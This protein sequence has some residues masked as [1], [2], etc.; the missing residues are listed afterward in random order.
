[1]IIGI[2]N[3]G[4]TSFK[5]KII[6]IG[7]NN[8]I[9]TLG[10]ANIDKI[11]TEGESNFTHSIGDNPT[12]REAVNIFGLEA[13]INLCLDWY[14]KN[15]VIS[16]PSD[17]QAMGF[18][19]I[20]GETN[21]ANMLTPEILAE[22]QRYAFV[23]PVHNIP[24]I[25]SIG[26]FSKIL[27]VPMVGVFEPSFHYSIPEFR[28]PLSFSWDWYEKLGIKKF[29]FHGSSHRYLTAMAIKLM[30]TENM[31]L[32]TIH[33]GGSSS[34]SAIKNGKSIDTSMSFSPNSGLL[35]GTRTGDIDGTALLYAMKELGI[36]VEQ[37]QAEI[38]NNAGL[39]GIASIGTE[40]FREILQASENGNKKARIAVD[41]Y[42][43]GIRKYIGSFAAI[44][45]GVDCL[46]L[47]G[48]IGEKNPKI[49]Q[50]LLEGFEFMGIK[51]D[52]QRNNE[53]AAGQGMISADYSFESKAKIFVIPTNEELVVASFTKKVVELGRDLKPE[54]MI[55]RV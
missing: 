44:L 17:I 11:K 33:L 48:G 20:L 9:K 55:F 36:S 43:D 37:A 10:Q 27:N 34:V 32:I 46:V 35:Q 19:C 6:D 15:K 14:V 47:S 54:E 5:S 52:E 22:M 3:V 21:G 53:I 8:E 24:Y 2:G 51:L 49:R 26:I 39:K 4:S 41:M 23:A 30:G 12:D 29:G 25:E 18:K 16:K 45:G 1:M 38:S 13:S 40:D 31:K 7:D 28:R 42:L 50:R